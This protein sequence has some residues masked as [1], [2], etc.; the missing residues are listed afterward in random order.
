MYNNYLGIVATIPLQY[1][2]GVTV[3]FPGIT[4][5]LGSDSEDVRLL[6][7]Y[8]NYISMYYPEI[9]GVTPTGY[10]GELT[11]N[12]VLAFEREFGFT[13]NG[14]VDAVLWNTITDVYAD[15]YQGNGLNDGQYPGYPVGS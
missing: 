7:E 4:L 1:T 14:I 10:F 15:L 13:P 12:A 5:R 8:L 6:Q 2:E 3:P 9:P 11:Q